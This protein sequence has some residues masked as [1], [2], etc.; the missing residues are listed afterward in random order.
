MVPQCRMETDE[1]LRLFQSM[2][3]PEF[4]AI[5]DRVLRSGSSQHDPLRA[6]SAHIPVR[7]TSAASAPNLL[8][9]LGNGGGIDKGKGKEGTSYWDLDAMVEMMESMN[10]RQRK[11]TGQQV[12]DLTLGSDGQGGSK[13]K[14]N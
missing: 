10:K 8:L 2:G 5:S 6:A 7:G 1:L 11:V 4:L 9:G 12:P 13:D 3:T 14:R